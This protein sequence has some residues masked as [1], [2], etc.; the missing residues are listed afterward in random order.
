MT[1]AASATGSSQADELRQKMTDILVEKGWI[2]PAPRVP[3][4]RGLRVPG[5]LELLAWR[6][7]REVA[8]AV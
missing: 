5:G 1:R 7:G 6:D 4:A 3:V 8:F 2:A